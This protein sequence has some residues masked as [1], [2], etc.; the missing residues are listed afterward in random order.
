[1]EPNNAVFFVFGCAALLTSWVLMLIV[2]WKEDYA[3]G[4]C[5]VLVP[6]LAYLFGLTR[7]DK[8]WESIAVAAVGWF[9]IFAAS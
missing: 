4:L 7:L 2:S 3:W 5:A 6:P 9:L 1:M 8:A